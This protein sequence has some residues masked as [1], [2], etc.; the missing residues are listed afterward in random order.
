MRARTK[1]LQLDAT[2]IGVLKDFERAGREARAA[3][4][5]DSSA[6]R[7]AHGF[8]VILID[9]SG[10]AKLSAVL[11]LVEKYESVFGSSLRLLIVKSYRLACLLDRARPFMR[12][13]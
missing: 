9:I 1:F 4:G 12:A 13:E 8:S 7:P 10:S 2:D 6:A 5:G 3:S 11:D